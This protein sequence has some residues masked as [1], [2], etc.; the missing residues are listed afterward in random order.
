[1]GWGRYTRK[2]IPWKIVYQEKYSTKTEALKRE[3]EIKAGFILK[4]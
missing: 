4:N 1:M 3:R 2:G